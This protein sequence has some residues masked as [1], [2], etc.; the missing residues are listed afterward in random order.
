VNRAGLAQR[1]SGKIE[2]L[3]IT[4]SSRFLVDPDQGRVANG[5]CSEENDIGEAVRRAFGRASS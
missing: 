5:S 2:D 3:N 1:G 4:M